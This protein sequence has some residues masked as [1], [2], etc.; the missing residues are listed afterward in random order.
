MTDHTNA[1]RTLS[2]RFIL[3]RQA[4]V[5][6]RGTEPISPSETYQAFLER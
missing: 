2:D 1:K 6:N 4:P 5:A 3:N